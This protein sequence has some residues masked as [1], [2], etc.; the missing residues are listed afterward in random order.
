MSNKR[1]IDGAG[2]IHLFWHSIAVTALV[3]ILMCFGWLVVI[4]IQR[5]PM[6]DLS[7]IPSFILFLFL[8]LSGIAGRVFVITTFISLLAL[9][10]KCGMNHLFFYKVDIPVA[11]M[12][13]QI[14]EILKK[15]NFRQ[16]DHYSWSRNQLL[17][18]YYFES[19]QVTLVLKTK[20]WNPNLKLNDELQE[21]A[22][23]IQTHVEKLTL[24]L[25]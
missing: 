16:Q 5:F 3:T 8:T 9:R 15:L 6:N 18:K 2:P 25:S 21:V 1:Q 7:Q 22:L 13:G 10:L 24:K 4:F 11:E 20:R 23:L 14:D 12:V 17:I 19:D